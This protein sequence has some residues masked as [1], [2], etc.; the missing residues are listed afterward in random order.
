MAATDSPED[1]RKEFEKQIGELK[2]EIGALRKSLASRGAE[3]YE[4]TRDAAGKAY[5][6]AKETAGDNL[7]LVRNQAQVVGEVVRENPGTAAT[8]LS[9][10]GVL[11]FVLGLVVGGLMAGTPRR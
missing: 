7:R 6:Q 10:A 1:M 9:S 4:D 11:G 8:V 2:K 3:I 5:S